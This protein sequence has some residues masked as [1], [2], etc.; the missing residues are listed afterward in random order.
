MAEK[1]QCPNCLGDAE[2]TGNKI[3][4]VTCD[5][6]F[7]IRKTGAASVVQVG[8]VEELECR[9]GA[10]EA[11]FAPEPEPEPANKEQDENGDDEEDILP[12]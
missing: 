3:T 4:C 9:I 6:I 7:E 1:V 8:K 5:A 12:R 11:L 10:L 2:K